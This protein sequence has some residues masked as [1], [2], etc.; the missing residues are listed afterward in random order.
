MNPRLIRFD[1]SGSSSPENEVRT[2][3]PSAGVPGPATPAFPCATF[4]DTPDFP[5]NHSAAAHN[6]EAFRIDLSRSRTSRPLPEKIRRGI[7]QLFVQ[8]LYLLLPFK[9][10][11]LRIPILRAMGARIGPG[12]LIE[13]N[14]RILC[15]WYLK[16][17]PFVAVARRVEILN[18]A[19][20]SIGSQTV[21][22]QDCYLCTGTHDYTHPHHPL[23][24]RP[25]RIQPESWIA[26]G[27]FIA[28]GVTVGRG[29]VIGARSVVTRDTPD[30][31]V[32]AG[33]PCKPLK[34]REI[35]EVTGSDP[36]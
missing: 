9:R 13:N 33:N 29:C 31:H 16:I 7:W 14:V 25:I 15:P 32:C 19:E 3:R 8:P 30:W 23:I 2:G 4:R 35:R 17:D 20:V 1:Q 11:P 12:V 27:V 36:A 6:P 22:S 10:N 18:F 28:P 21:V 24:T 26:S 34:T 5:M